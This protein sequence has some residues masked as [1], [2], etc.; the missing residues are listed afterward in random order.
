MF[1]FFFFDLHQGGKKN[2][3]MGIAS[4][5]CHSSSDRKVTVIFDDFI[6]QLVTSFL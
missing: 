1:P 2:S 4:V 3:C 5:A 6:P